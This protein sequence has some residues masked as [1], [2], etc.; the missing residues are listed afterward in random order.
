LVV[1]YNPQ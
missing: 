1:P